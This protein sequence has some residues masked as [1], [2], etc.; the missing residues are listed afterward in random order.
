M[1]RTGLQ[2]FIL[3]CIIFVIMSAGMVFA[4]YLPRPLSPFQKSIITSLANGLAQANSSQEITGVG[5]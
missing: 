4:Y 5:V 3:A 1:K 2:D